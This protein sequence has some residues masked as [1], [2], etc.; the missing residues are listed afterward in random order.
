MP[1]LG[2]CWWPGRLEI[3][4]KRVYMCFRKSNI[5]SCQL[6][7][8]ETNFGISQL[9]WIWNYS[10]WCWFEDGRS[11]CARSLG[12][13][14]WGIAITR[15]KQ[16][17]FHQ[18]FRKRERDIQSFTVQ[19][20]SKR[21]IQEFPEAGTVL[22]LMNCLKWITCQATHNLLKVSPSCTSSRTMKL[23]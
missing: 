6:D 22:V 8:Q 4:L 3:N 19:Q 5:S 11:S 21:N 13:C 10:F 16:E 18:I 2:L 17:A 1:R 12:H 14:F 23:W 9:H 15:D 20:K 7:V